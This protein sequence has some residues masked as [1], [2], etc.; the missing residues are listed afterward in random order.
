MITGV[1]ERPMTAGHAGE[2]IAAQVFDIELEMSASQS[3][4]DK[5]FRGSPLVGRSVN[6]KV[7]PRAGRIARP[8][9]LGEARH[10]PGLFA[11]RGS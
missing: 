8:H 5:R 6:I 1:I 11:I 9:E 7:V 2:W 4:I 10:L 3:A